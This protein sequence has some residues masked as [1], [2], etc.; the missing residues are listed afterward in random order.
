LLPLV[1]PAF[2]VLFR[3]HL[4]AAQRTVLD[5]DL[6]GYETQQLIVGFADLV[7]STDLAQHLTMGEFGLVL[8]TFENLA[9]DTVTAAGGRVIKLI[10]DE[11]LYTAPDATSA[12]AIALDLADSFR[13]HPIV[14][15]VRVGLAGGQVMLRDGDVFGPVV[16]LADRAV[17]VADPGE[18]VATA[19]VADAAGFRPERRD[20]HQLK[21]FSQA[22]VLQ[23]LE[24]D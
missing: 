14:P 6:V 5:N 16:N 19:D 24:R 21:G 9:S 3:Q 1:A 15:P 11:I 13:D 7:G 22:I 18:V 17:K 2:D 4:L 10:G 23:R 20:L 8:T 12:C